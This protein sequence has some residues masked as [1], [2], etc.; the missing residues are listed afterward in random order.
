[1]TIGNPRVIKVQ[2]AAKYSGLDIKVVTDIVM[3]TTNTTPAWIAKFGSS[4]VPAFEGTDGTTLIESGAIAYY[5]KCFL[6]PPLEHHNIK[7]QGRFTSAIEEFKSKLGWIIGI[8]P[9]Y[10]NYINSAAGS[11]AT[12]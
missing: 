8:Q 12:N 9:S 3:G 7:S 6:C 4:Q 2:V 11:P 5:G 1:M 10:P